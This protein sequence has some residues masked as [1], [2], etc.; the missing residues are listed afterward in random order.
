[1]TLKDNSKQMV[2]DYIKRNKP[3]FELP[4]RM[5]NDYVYGNFKGQKRINQGVDS[6][7]LGYW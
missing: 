4:K 1:M 5:I 2:L 7:K 6:T 3:C